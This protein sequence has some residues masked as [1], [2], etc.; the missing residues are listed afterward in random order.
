MSAKNYYKG[1]MVS[2]KDYSM[3]RLK[4][5]LL[6]LG[7]KASEDLLSSVDGYFLEHD[8]IHGSQILLDNNV[9]VNVPINE[10]FV[11]KYS[12]FELLNRSEEW[13]IAKD[14]LSIMK[15]KPLLMPHWV[16]LPLN[17][18]IKIGDIVR[19]HS[20]TIL[21]CTPIKKCVFEKLNEKCKFCTFFEKCDI[22]DY[23][24]LELVKKAFEIIFSQQDNGYREVAIGGATPNLK[25]FGAKYYLNVVKIIKEIRPDVEISLEI[26]PPFDLGLLYEIFSAGVNSIIMNIE[27]FDETVRQKIC[28]GKSKVPTLHYFRAWEKALSTFGKNKVSSV[29]IVGL[30]DKQ[31]TVNGGRKMLEMGV[32]PTLIPFRPYDLCELRYLP[33]TLPEYYLSIYRQIF[34]EIRGK[35]VNPLKQP[36]CTHCGGCSLETLIMGATK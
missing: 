26:I 23:D 7:V 27:I 21:F 1:E 3:L 5:N 2:F 6:C 22:T 15:C 9:V 17:D 29:L 28:P 14:G 30:E 4:A 8:F 35:E 25:D 19:P 11:F 31:N 12:P 16:S 24:N 13:F 20:N 36:G 18:S 32:I 34:S 10:K 33:P